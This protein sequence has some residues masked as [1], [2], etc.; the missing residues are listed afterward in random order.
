MCTVLLCELLLYT[1]N[2]QYNLAIYDLE[3]L[4]TVNS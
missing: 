1:V 2:L 3:F 4:V